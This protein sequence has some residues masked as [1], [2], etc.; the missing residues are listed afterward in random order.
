[1]SSDT[2]GDK[3]AFDE[4]RARIVQRLRS[5]HSEIEEAV[6]SR[7][8]R[9]V[10]NSIGDESP[11]YHE[12]LPATVASVLDYAMNAIECGEDSEPIPPAVAAQA[13]RGARAGVSPG[14]IQRRYFVGYRVFGEFVTQEIEHLE[15]LNSGQVVHHLHRAQEA[16]LEHLAAAIEHEYHQEQDS[17]GGFRRSA[18]VQRL[19][20]GE[21][22]EP[23]E[24]AELDYEIDAYWHLGLI[25]SGLSTEDIAQTLGRPQ[26]C[27]ILCVQLNDRV[28]T[29]LGAQDASSTEGE[30]LSVTGRSGVALAIG[31]PGRGFDGWRLTHQQARAAF[32]VALRRPQQVARYADSRLL[33]AALQN[34]TLARSLAQKYLGPLRSQSDGGAKLRHTLR[35]YID[36]ECNATSTAHGLQIGRH[37]VESRVHTAERLI[38]ATLRKCLPELDVALRMDQLDH[39][40]LDGEPRH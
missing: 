7:I 12:A 36:S 14:T 29:W 9:D 32:A 15:L 18:I 16:L 23:A 37:T 10:P 24:L 4:I 40:F 34:E 13:R 2:S 26:G 3:K 1:M 22:V 27:K 39:A 11:E 20:S 25:S 8:Q 38:G 31:E 5:R 19:L 21:P 30:H 28:F 33:A 35:T 17:I 6:Y